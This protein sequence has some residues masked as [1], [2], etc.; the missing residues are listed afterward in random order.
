MTAGSDPTRRLTRAA[1]AGAVVAFGLF[2]LLLTY[3]RPWD[4]APRETLGN[5]YD[6]QAESLLHGHL[7]VDPAELSFEGFLINGRTFEYQ[8]PVPALMRLPVEA[9]TDRFHGRLT[10][11]SML[12][13]YALTLWYLVR[14]QLTAR[15]AIQAD[16]PAGRAEALW[17]GMTTFGLAT[18]SLLFLASKAW[19]YHEALLWGIAF[20]VGSL[21]NLAAWLTSTQP[22]SNRPWWGDRRLVAA[23]ILAGLALLTR[24]AVGAGPIGAL[25][26]AGAVQCAHLL[27]R[28]RRPRLA[29]R[30]V[31][32][33]GWRHRSGAG[34][35]VL[36]LGVLVPVGLYG[37]VNQAKFGSPFTLPADKQVLVQF[38]RTRQE[39]FAEHG[40][41][42]FGV[43]FIP[44]VATQAL[45]PDAI[46]LGG[47]FPF[48]G[49]PHE[50][51]A[52]LGGVL[53]AERDWSSSVTASEPLLALLALLGAVAV[54]TPK[55]FGLAPGAEVF[56][57]PMLGAVAGGI[58]FFAIGYM[59]N[60]YMS[61][62]FPLLALGAVV[63]AQVLFRLVSRSAGVLRRVGWAGVA[64]LTL[65]GAWVNM[66][67]GV[68]YQRVIAP[69]SSTEQRARWLES[70]VRFGPAPGTIS[71]GLLEPLPARPE[72]GQ[73]AVVGDCAAV[74]RSNGAIWLPLKGDPSTGR[75][76]GT[77]QLAELPTVRTTLLVGRSGDSENRLFIE[78]T[79]GAKLRFGAITTTL[80]SEIEG[81]PGPATDL[82]VGR[83]Y[84]VDITFDW[85]SGYAEV[86][87]DGRELL[88]TNL[89]LV[90][91]V[92]VVD[93]AFPGRFTP[94]PPSGRLCRALRAG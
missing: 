78:P 37:A 28:S 57:I 39:F 19:I 2:L 92:P 10:R 47:A 36:V 88:S 45:R 21:A 34:L 23:S 35:L 26:L 8:G 68:E 15:C 87:L 59:A 83:H 32:A 9:V 12:A 60:R 30:I 54:L 11:I 84:P 1:T 76:R 17:T 25:S 18:S 16:A 81:L 86:R 65:W 5:F 61:D 62:L 75:F 48:V 41:S 63:G 27:T 31:G 66:G 70:Q 56:R 90:P 64:A 94:T 40:N 77:L 44:S 58:G 72:L 73:V 4:L 33:G 24:S 43:E 71:V 69:G 89:A 52:A 14:L 13:A 85:R 82:R 22:T 7:A 80:G 50:R 51:P 20:S 46:R 74:Y 93:P 91:A 29:G 6:A 53:F 42:L 3:G 79:N 67:L 38:D 55:R 49:F